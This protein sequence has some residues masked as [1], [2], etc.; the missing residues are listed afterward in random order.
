ML[1]VRWVRMLYT[2]TCICIV[3]A[4][5]KVWSLLSVSQAAWIWW[6]EH[7]QI[8]SWNPDRKTWSI[9]N[10]RRWFR[11]WSLGWRPSGNTGERRFNELCIL[12]CSKNCYVK[13]LFIRQW[14]LLV[15]NSLQCLETFLMC[16]SPFQVA[17]V[18]M[19]PC[20]VWRLSL[21]LCRLAVLCV[22]ICVWEP[23]WPPLPWGCGREVCILYKI[24]CSYTCAQF[25]QL[26]FCSCMLWH[27]RFHHYDCLVVPV[28][29][30]TTTF[31]WEKVTLLVEYE[32]LG[33]SLFSGGCAP[34]TLRLRQWVALKTAREISASAL[35]RSGTIH[36]WLYYSEV[37]EWMLTKVCADIL[38][39]WTCS[40]NCRFGHAELVSPLVPVHSYCLWECD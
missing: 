3:Y 12:N 26:L 23:K 39:M 35:A 6:K 33:S 22:F 9:L 40:L 8:C 24:H 16:C 18:H 37:G 27:S 31:P 5:T 2:H 20:H 38:W 21:F 32:P 14:W 36:T 15:E 29:S 13:S 25:S 28:S 19:V 4:L 11:A 34:D 30:I 10:Y 1:P 17:V 7:W